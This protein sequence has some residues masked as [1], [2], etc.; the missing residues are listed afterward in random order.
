V[1]PDSASSFSGLPDCLI[2]GVIEQDHLQ[3][4]AV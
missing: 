1:L 4:E 2:I 3:L